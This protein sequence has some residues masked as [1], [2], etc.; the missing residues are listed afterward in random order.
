MTLEKEH[1]EQNLLLNKIWD[2]LSEGA[3]NSKSGFHLAVLGTSLN[4]S[5][6]IRTVVLRK[7]DMEDSSLIIHTDLRSE[8]YNEIKSNPN[9]SLIFYSK[10]DKVQ[11]RL[12][13][14]ATLHTSD[15]LANFQWLARFILP[16]IDIGIGQR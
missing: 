6:K 10:E 3:A 5:P 12:E 8:K 15:L 7:V 14:I 4:N 1:I 16:G 11:I 2:Y 13:G 9:V